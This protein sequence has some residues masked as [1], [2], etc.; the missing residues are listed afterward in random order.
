V[1]RKQSFENT[2]AR[3]GKNIEEKMPPNLNPRD[4]SG[5][6]P[7]RDFEAWRMN[8]NGEWAKQ[9]KMKEERE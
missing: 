5:K 8:N 3:P 1:K 4:R 7:M 2:N 6:R 9:T